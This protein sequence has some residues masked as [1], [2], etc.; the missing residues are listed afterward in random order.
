[1]LNTHSVGRAVV[2]VCG[3]TAHKSARHVSQ[4]AHVSILR[5]HVVAEQ[6]NHSALGCQTQT[7]HSVNLQLSATGNCYLAVA[8]A[9]TTVNGFSVRVK[10]G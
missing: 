4:T 1:M 8:F 9:I 6:E 7:G 5:K 2:K 3:N 10:D